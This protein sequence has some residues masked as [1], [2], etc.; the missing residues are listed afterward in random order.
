MTALQLGCGVKP[1]DGV[2]NHDKEKHSEF[3]DVAHDLEIFPWPWKDEEFEKVIA[4]D[5]MEHL[6]CDV[7]EWLDECW[8]ILKPAGLLV[9]QLPAWNH[10]VG[11]IDPT[12]RRLFHPQT[13]EYWDK[14]TFFYKEYG[15]FYYQKSNRWW[16]IER[17][18][19]KDGGSNLFYV[20]R[21]E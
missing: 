10:E 17:V 15:W 6:K 7:Y 8:R 18:E 16:K 4:L 13:F 14:R 12:H 2:I 9:L 3:V 21:K 5:V 11:H 20:L 19:P 1:I